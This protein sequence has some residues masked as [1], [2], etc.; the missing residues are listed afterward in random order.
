MIPYYMEHDYWHS[1]AT[2]IERARQELRPFN[3]SVDYLHYKHGDRKSYQ[4]ACQKIEKSNTD[5][6]L[7]SS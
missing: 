7:F 1:V 3:V 5:A 6:L 2:G 4:D